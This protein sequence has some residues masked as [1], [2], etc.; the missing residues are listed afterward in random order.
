M[1]VWMRVVISLV[2]M[3]TAAHAGNISRRIMVGEQ[4]RTYT[5][6]VPASASEQ[7]AA[8]VIAFHGGTGAGRSM[9][10]LSGFS[11]LADREGFLVAYPD[12]L[13][14]HWRD[15]RAMPRGMTD[16]HAD[17]VAFVAALLDD[18]AKF[19]TIDSRRIFAAGMS[20]G[21][22]FSHY[23]ALKM[24]ERIAAIAA[25]AGGIATGIAA[26]FKPAAPVSVLIIHGRDDPLVLY[27]GGPVS[28][29]H[30]SIVPTERAVRLWLAAD[31]ISSTPQ[32]RRTVSA[33]PAGDCTEHWQSWSGGRNAS[34]VTLIALDGGGHTWP[35]G[36]QYLP[37]IVVGA[38]C[39]EL[40]ATRTIWEFFSQHPKP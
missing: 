20:N 2:V 11:A 7:G 5:L 27:N 33:K 18:A 28:R 21:A 4:A 3:C 39:P 15:G 22:I 13:Q 32:T 23:V 30:G 6:H 38:V 8:L 10:A 1:S 12:G 31:G 19:H 37:K 9:A 34:A 35:G 25:V 24:P 40:D 14:G 29:T 36:R 17:D 16:E 26:D